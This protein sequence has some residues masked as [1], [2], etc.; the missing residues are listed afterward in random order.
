MLVYQRVRHDMSTIQSLH[1][2]NL[3]K[4]TLAAYGVPPKV[5]DERKVSRR[6]ASLFRSQGKNQALLPSENVTLW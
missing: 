5:E 4:G 1:L 3:K 2:Q 6:W